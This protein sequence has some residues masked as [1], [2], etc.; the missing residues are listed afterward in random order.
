M[1]FFSRPHGGLP[2]AASYKVAGMA[3]SNKIASYKIAR[4]AASN[5]GLLQSVQQEPG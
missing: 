5:S 4:M 1:C 3:A 2:Q